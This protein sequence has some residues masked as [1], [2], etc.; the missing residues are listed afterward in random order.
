MILATEEKEMTRS[1]K[2]KRRITRPAKDDS[3]KTRSLSTSGT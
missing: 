3:A 2:D 1:T